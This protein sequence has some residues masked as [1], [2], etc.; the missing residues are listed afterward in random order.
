MS[1]DYWALAVALDPEATDAVANF[2]WEAGAAGVVEEGEDRP[3]ALR[4]FFPPGTDPTE[5]G[6][7]LAGFLGELRALAIPTG[8][9]TL[10]VTRV[11]EEAWA[12]AWRAHFGPLRIGRR[13]LV[14]PPWEPPPASAVDEPR[15]VVVIEPGRAFGT[16]SH[17]STRGC[18][19]LLERALGTAPVDRVLDVGTGSGILA[20]A[21]ARLVATTTVTALDVDPDAV[22]AAGENA[23]RNE[24]ADRVHV[25]LGGPQTWPG[26]PAA[27]VVANLLAP[28][29]I[30]LAP[31]LG[32][33]TGTPGRLVAGGLLVHE[34]P[35]VAAAF[36]P[37]GFALA[38]VLE[39]EG[40][41]SLLLA[42]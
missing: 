12:D 25:E 11:P 32:R 7:R 26:P 42:R 2:L 33:C 14:V 10:T 38:E 1:A 21:A 8:P 17:A 40:W 9:A 29:L 28:A 34:A 16:G 19:E 27:L 20:I 41:A 6:R 13:L 22:A 30:A 37:E 35:A 15:R 39:H 3:V 4:A 24:V 5:T 18:L 31:A 36:V 23:R